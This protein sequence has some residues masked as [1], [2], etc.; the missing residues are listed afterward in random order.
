LFCGELNP[1]ALRLRVEIDSDLSSGCG[2]CKLARMA[3][4][5]KYLKGQ[6]LLDGGKLAGSFFHRTVVLVCEH[7]AEGALGLVLNR[8]SENKVG[9]MIVADL[10][11]TFK[12]QSL[13]L[14]G[15]VQ[16]AALSF[17]HS[18]NFI[19]DANVLPD[20]SVS[21]SLEALVDLGESFS[22]TQTV[23]IFAG[24]SGWSPGQL[25]EELKRGAWLVHP[26]SLDL[27]FKTEPT[28]LWKT[29]LDKKGWKFKLMAQSPEDLSWN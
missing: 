1:G 4:V 7:N 28:N 8:V 20:L 3:E 11:D 15:P 25:E 18:D 22:S 6:L 9:E 2:C 14:G 13:F 5:P 27:V 24:Y 17:L 10:P 21:H 12:E 26:A 29:I 23:K 19:P 16:P